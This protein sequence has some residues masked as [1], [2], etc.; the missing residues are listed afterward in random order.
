M[1]QTIRLAALFS[2][3]IFS[4]SLFAQVGEE[5]AVCE[6]KILTETDE[7]SAQ[8]CKICAH[9]LSEDLTAEKEKF[10]VAYSIEDYQ[11]NLIAKSS[12]VFGKADHNN[13]KLWETA[14]VAE[15]FKLISFD[16]NRKT[17]IDPKLNELI[18]KAYPN[19]SPEKVQSLIERN[20]VAYARAGKEKVGSSSFSRNIAEK[21]FKVVASDQ[22]FSDE[23]SNLKTTV[24][25]SLNSLENN[26]F[27][28]EDIDISLTSA[29]KVSN[30]SEKGPTL[31][32]EKEFRKEELISSNELNENTSQSYRIHYQEYEKHKQA[33]I[34]KHNKRISKSIYQKDPKRLKIEQRR[35]K[36]ELA[37][38]QFGTPKKISFTAPLGVNINDFYQEIKGNNP[39]YFNCRLSYSADKAAHQKSMISTK[40][41]SQESEDN[42]EILVLP[43]KKAKTCKLD[44]NFGDDQYKLSS[45]MNSEIDNCVS[46]IPK[47]A[48]NVKIEIESCA[49][50]VRTN[51]EEFNKS[52]LLL[53]KSRGNAIA[54][55]IPKDKKYQISLNYEGTNKMIADNGQL[56][57][58]GTCGPWVTK[59]GDYK[60]D[61]TNCMEKLSLNTDYCKNTPEY[62]VKQQGL[63]WICN[64]ENGSNYKSGGLKEKL[65][66]FRYN[67]IKI[68]YEMPPQL[69]QNKDDKAFDPALLPSNKKL[70]YIESMPHITC[71]MPRAKHESWSSYGERME[72]SWDDFSQYMSELSFKPLGSGGDAG[73]GESHV[74]TS[75]LCAAYH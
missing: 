55:R 5:G 70:S 11:Q 38:V 71:L 29:T 50:T 3:L 32:R 45:D 68:T 51:K 44:S 75:G 30:R 34:D 43:P 4:H 24:G 6:K 39:S 18:S 16:K 9:L 63:Y 56:A 54:S 46:D 2:W 60:M 64:Q 40:K 20:I 47:D 21:V 61:P 69:D 37:S 49:S 48:L 23:L 13:Y 53:S 65:K 73:G 41:S 12:Y 58:T 33:I 25:K 26:T 36:K 7:F 14:Q 62:M 31:S 10:E 22:A 8:N 74:K 67:K 59:I 28:Q 72:D 42:S 35:L 19:N 52:N 66:E 57:A 27:K 15:I 1:N 17:I